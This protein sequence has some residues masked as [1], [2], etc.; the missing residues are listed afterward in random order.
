MLAKEAHDYAG[1]ESE[2]LSSCRS[3]RSYTSRLGDERVSR[4]YEGTYVQSFLCI[5]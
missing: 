2:M 5:V 4:D 3:T 1:Q